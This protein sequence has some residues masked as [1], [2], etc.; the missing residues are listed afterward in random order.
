MS[1]LSYLSE[2][3]APMVTTL[4]GSVMFSGI[5]FVSLAGWNY[6]AS[7]HGADTSCRV[8]ATRWRS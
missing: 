1:S 6:Y 3:P 4:A 5:F 8:S 7:W 2:R